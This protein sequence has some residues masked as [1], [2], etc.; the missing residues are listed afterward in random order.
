MSVRRGCWRWA[1][2]SEDSRG[3]ATIESRALCIAVESLETETGL[4]RV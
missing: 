3:L 4:R 1:C 2:S